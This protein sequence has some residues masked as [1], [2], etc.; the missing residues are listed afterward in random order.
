MFDNVVGS[1]NKRNC[2]SFILFLAAS[3]LNYTTFYDIGDLPLPI[4]GFLFY[5]SVMEMYIDL[6]NY[7]Q[8]H[9]PSLLI[10]LV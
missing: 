7:R 9:H 2:I 10:S 4:W 6:Y 5:M 8:N 1:G 3:V